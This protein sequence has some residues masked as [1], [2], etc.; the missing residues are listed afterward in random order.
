[1]SKANLKK[2]FKIRYSLFDIRY[3]FF[4]VFSFP[5][6][7]AI[8]IIALFSVLFFALPAAAQQAA[9]ES[10]SLDELISLSLQNDSNFRQLA[11]QYGVTALTLGKDRDALWPAL[12]LGYDHN[13]SSYLDEI[14]GRYTVNVG[15][16]YPLRDGGR[17]RRQIVYDRGLLD[18]LDRRISAYRRDRAMEVFKKYVDLL[19]GT[20]NIDVLDQA[21]A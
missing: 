17:R 12:R 10:A 4:S 19:A 18:S 16:S 5:C 15:A 14:S 9:P 6:I 8:T 21:I 3:S 2:N 20:A 11:D 7:A 13:R 1:M